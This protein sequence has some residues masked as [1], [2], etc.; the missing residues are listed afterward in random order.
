MLHFSTLL[1][2]LAHFGLALLWGTSVLS[3]GQNCTATPVCGPKICENLK[4]TLEVWKEKC[5][6]FA[7][8]FLCLQQKHATLQC[9]ICIAV[10][11]CGAVPGSA[12]SQICTNWSLFVIKFFDCAFVLLFFA[13]KICCTLALPLLANCQ[14]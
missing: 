2:Q 4:R 3:P 7:W 9:E 13:C 10:G 12:A 5:S 11:L 6:F 8:L 14:S 1:Q